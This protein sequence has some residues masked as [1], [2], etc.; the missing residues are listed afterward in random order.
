MVNP[1]SAKYI[2]I[3]IIFI[4]FLFILLLKNKT[5]INTNENT[6]IPIITGDETRSLPNTSIFSNKVN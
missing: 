6:D 4:I 2:I 5:I 1:N 3:N